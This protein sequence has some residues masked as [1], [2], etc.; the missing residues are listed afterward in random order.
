MALLAQAPVAVLQVFCTQKVSSVA[1][2]LT[3]VVGLT[4]HLYGSGALSQKSLPLQALPSSWPAQ[5][6]SELQPHW[7]VPET[8]LP[9]EQLSLT[10]QPL[11][12]SQPAVLFSTTQPS[13]V[14][15]VSVVHGL[16]S[17]QLTAAPALHAPA[18]QTSPCV[19]TLGAPPVHRPVCQ[20]SLSVQAL[21][22]LQASVL[23]L[24][25]HPEFGSH[26]SP[27][28]G[29]SSS[30]AS[31]W[32]L[33]APAAHE[34][35][36]VQAGRRHSSAA[37]ANAQKSRSHAHLGVSPLARGR[38]LVVRSLPR[39]PTRTPA[40]AERKVV[41]EVVTVRG[42]SG[43]R[44][45]AGFRSLTRPSCRLR[46]CG[47]G[48]FANSI[49]LRRGHH[50]VAALAF[51]AERGAPSST[52]SWG[53]TSSCLPPPPACS[54]LPCCTC[55]SCRD[56]RRHSS[57]VAAG[58]HRPRRCRERLAR[59]PRHRCP[60]PRRRVRRCCRHTFRWLPRTA[61]QEP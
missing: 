52:G 45:L 3:M 35:P 6:P 20:T 14:S 21:P 44:P 40:W 24:C 41:V 32:P 46:G 22:S 17:P 16:P 33:Q 11:P 39:R 7:L 58:R 2:Q 43:F 47:Q 12:S 57:A 31:A 55:R 42:P 37:R 49:W 53:H 1:S 36:W 34:S 15:Q 50:R 59:V 60:D 25:T 18:A 9:P 61:L 23:V 48:G 26:A 5:S 10:V 56:W 30:H 27:V 54:R 29:L 13:L 8:Q 51:L 19:Q 28:Q 38:A 4:L